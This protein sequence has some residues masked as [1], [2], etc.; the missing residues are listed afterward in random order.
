MIMPNGIVEILNCPAVNEIKDKALNPKTEV[1]PAD[2]YDVWDFLLL[3]LVQ[4]NGQRPI[5]VRNITEET[6]KKAHIT[7]DGWATLTVSLLKK[8]RSNNQ[9]LC[10]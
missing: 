8:R 5:A 1:V 9:I 3:R 2:F 7:S 4:T 6:L 10:K